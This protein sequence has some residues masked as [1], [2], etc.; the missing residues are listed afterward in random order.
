MN[1]IIMS[2]NNAISSSS[3]PTYAGKVNEALQ[4]ILIRSASFSAGANGTIYFKV[5]ANDN[6]AVATIVAIDKT[7]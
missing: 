2:L 4:S 6:K 3:Q 7:R 1:W 5:N